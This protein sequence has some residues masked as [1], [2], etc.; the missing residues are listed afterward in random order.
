LGDQGVS[1]R[2]NTN[3]MFVLDRSYSMVQAGVC[4]QVASASEQFINDFVESR[5]TV[6]LVTFQSTA[7]VDYAPRTTFKTQINTLLGQMQCTGY[8]TTAEALYMAYKQLQNLNQ[9]NALNVIVMFT[10][11]IPDSFVGTFQMKTYADT[12]YDPFNYSTY[13][14][15]PP[16]GCLPSDTLTGVVTDTL[17]VAGATGY[18]GGIYPDV[19]TAISYQS[20]YIVPASVI[21]APGCAFINNSNYPTYTVT[22]REDIAYLPATDYYTNALTGYK[23]LDYYPAGSPYAGQP[24]IDTPNSVMNAAANAANNMANTI[25]NSGYFIYTIGLGGT[26]YQAIDTDLLMR[27]ANDPLLPASEYN[28]TQPTGHFVYTTASGIAQAFA[29]I[30]SLMLHLS[31]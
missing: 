24:R 3:V 14:Q 6:G 22:V 11:G 7:K 5:D 9:P 26:Q 8:T 18:T 20:P 12:R 13:E 21:T 23:P 25:R 2:R 30:E 10:D 27:I 31:Q 19:S 28:S 17:G 15:V 29:E 16:T 4:S 1:T